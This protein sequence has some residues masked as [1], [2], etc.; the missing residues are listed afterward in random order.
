[1]RIGTERGALMQMGLTEKEEYQIFSE[2]GFDSIDYSLP[3]YKN[4]IWQLP[5]SELR[6][7]MEEQ[8]DLIH[9][10]GLIVGQTHS[11]I[12]SDWTICP[13]TK[14]AQWHAQVQ[15]IKAT[16]YLGSP[17]TVIHPMCPKGQIRDEGY[18]EYAKELNMEFYNFLKPYLEEYN[19]KG[20]I[21]NLFIDDSVLGRTEK[22][23]CSTAENQID[24]IETLNSDCFV[25]CLDVGHATLAGEDPV[26][27]IYKLGKKYLHVTHMHDN[28][29]INDDHFMPGI[30]KIDWYSIGKALNDIGYED[31]FS[32]EANRTFR[33]IGP[34][35]KELTRDFLEV[36]IMLAKEI[37]NIK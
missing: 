3:Y 8:R 19:V 2:L 18:Y 31:V 1:M 25:A 12:A 29:Y 23:C 4:P 6:A 34:Y 21:E 20:A 16:A 24:Y 27:M 30:G 7:I 37:A 5:D 15:A 13:E 35:G 17:Y 28:D 9:K 33:R 14:M 32:Y 22:T 36:Y 10:C 26:K 11:P